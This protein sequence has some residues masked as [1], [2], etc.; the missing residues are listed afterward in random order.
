VIIKIE[1]T[2]KELEELVLQ[3]LHNKLGQIPLSSDNVVIEVKSKQNYKSEW[4]RADYRA[5]YSH[6]KV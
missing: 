3:D 5:T 6:V 2:Q 4:E 1:Y